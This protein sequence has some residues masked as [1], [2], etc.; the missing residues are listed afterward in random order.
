[1]A[2]GIENLGF[3]NKTKIFFL[4]TIV[5]LSGVSAIFDK[6]SAFGNSNSIPVVIFT[7][8]ASMKKIIN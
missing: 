4:F 7:C 6:F 8:V 2:I 3:G 5:I 1:M